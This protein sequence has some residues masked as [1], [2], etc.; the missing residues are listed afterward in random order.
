MCSRHNQVMAHLAS[1][2]LLCRVASSNLQPCAS[3]QSWL[4][5][6]ATFARLPHDCSG[7][8]SCSQPSPR[9]AGQIAAGGAWQGGPLL[10][11]LNEVAEPLSGRPIGD[12][13]LCEKVFNPHCELM[14]VLLRYCSVFHGLL[15]THPLQL[16]CE[17]IIVHSCLNEYLEHLIHQPVV[18]ASLQVPARRPVC[19]LPR[20]EH[21][22]RCDFE[23]GGTSSRQGRNPALIIHGVVS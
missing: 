11:L 19:I 17:K 8:R 6:A 9:E 18:T 10:A 12:D 21:P 14:I 1:V 20:A 3:A 16:C 7:R 13:H 4:A 5:S 22:F 15:Q 2:S 23:L